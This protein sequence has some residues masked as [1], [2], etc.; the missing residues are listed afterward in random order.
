MKGLL[1]RRAPVAFAAAA[2]LAAASAGAGAAPPAKRN[3]AVASAYSIKILVPGQPAAGTPAATA[4][5]DAVALGAA[6]TYPAADGSIAA[7]G[8]LSANASTDVAL[9]SAG[10]TASTDVS[11]LQLFGGEISATDISVHTALTA[12]PKAVTPDLAGQKLIGLVILGQPVTPAPNTTVPL[13]DWGSAVV[14]EQ[15]TDVTAPKGRTGGHA[16]IAALDIHLTAPHGGLP[17]GTQIVAGYAEASANVRKSLPPAP[18]GSGTTTTTTPPP[19]P[20]APKPPHGGGTTHKKPQ[21][22]P[23]EPRRPPFGPSPVKAPPR[24]VHPK[25]T[26]GGYVFPVYG[27]VS[28][29]D[30]FGAYSA[31]LGFHH[32]DDIF[33]P[34]GAPIL[35]V[36]KGTVF[37]VGWNTLGGNRLWLRDRQGNEFYYAHLSAYSPIAVN[38]ARVNAGDVLG[39]VGNT[40]DAR[41]TP[42]HLHF[43]IHPVSMLGLGYDGVVDPTSYLNAWHHLRNLTFS[44]GVTTSTTSAYAR[45]RPKQSL[46]P[47]PGAILLQVSDIS[48][49]TGLDREAVRRSLAAGA[50][51][52]ASEDEN[53]LLGLTQKRPAKK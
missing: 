24:N 1:V 48:S 21:P 34:L 8:P 10:G 49:A 19:P 35:A 6:F 47:E 7:T 36:A 51:V 2:A 3:Q 33:A 11:S 22:K 52:T 4:P 46:A 20:P 45:Q 44:A 26:A 43:E 15:K 9:R 42:Y 14:L 16:S 5:P 39:F 27:P 30:S 38:G 17:A 29:T 32:G 23:P 18:P 13:A 40:G 31:L 25:L 37:S 53:A 50:A 12:K 41:T 28:Y